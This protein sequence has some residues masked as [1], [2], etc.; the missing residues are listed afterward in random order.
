MTK[1]RSITTPSIEHNEVNLLVEF[2]WLNRSLDLPEYPW[3]K[4]E[5]GK[6]WGSQVAALTKIIKSFGIS[7]EQIGFYIYKNSVV[8]INSLEFGRMAVVAARVLPEVDLDDLHIIYQDKKEK[9]D[10]IKSDFLPIAHKNY[11]NKGQRGKS[12]KEFIKDLENGEE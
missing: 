10:S 5:A 3:R 12:L 11:L 6:R 2:M 7:V 9:Y 4:A 8:S 1:Y